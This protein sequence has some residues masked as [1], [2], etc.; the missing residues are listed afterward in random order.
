MKKLQFTGSNV[1]EVAD[2]L[3]CAHGDML[4]IPTPTTHIEIKY[5]DG[6]TGRLNKGD[7]AIMRDDGAVR[8]DRLPHTQTTVD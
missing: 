8:I 3:G 5:A 1:Y 7:W 6:S 4:V 2:F